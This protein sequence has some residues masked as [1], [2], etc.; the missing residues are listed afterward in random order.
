MAENYT[1]KANGS[2]RKKSLIFLILFSVVAG[3]ILCLI[4]QSQDKENIIAGN[5]LPE[6]GSAVAGHLPDM[7]HEQI[8]AQ[9]QKDTDRS[10]FSFK[11]NSRPVFQNGRKEG[12]LRIE[13]PNHN[14]YPFVVEIFLNETGEKVYDSG[15]IL[16]NH[17]ISHAKLTKILQKGDYSA[18][19][20][21]NVYDPETKEYCGKSAATLTLIVNQ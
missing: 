14:I 3:M 12:T 13:N 15:A 1:P 20:Y 16:P 2:K 4:F 21:I 7:T 18:T 11:I 6:Q 9:M 17:H 19:A 5:F 10:L 8:K